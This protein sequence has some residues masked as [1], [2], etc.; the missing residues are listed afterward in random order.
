MLFYGMDVSRKNVET[1]FG[2]TDEYTAFD[3]L[4]ECFCSNAR[5]S[6]KGIVLEHYFGKEAE[7]LGLEMIIEKVCDNNKKQRFDHFILT[8]KRLFRFEVRTLT[9]KRV[10]LGFKDKTQR[11][12]VVLPSGLEWAT[13][14]RKKT[15]DFDF[16]AIGLVNITGNFEDFAYLH[17]S[18]FDSY[19]F[20][21]EENKFFNEEDKKFISENFYAKSMQVPF[22]LKKPYTNKLHEIIF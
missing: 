14:A 10:N 7:K 15:Q 6:I 2:I 9:N 20:T 13:T 21:K 3:I 4:A 18:N 17:K 1:F 11:E 22:P 16:L 12:D 5:S 19:R 8:E